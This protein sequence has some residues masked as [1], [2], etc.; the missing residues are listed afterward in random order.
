ML[1]THM[2]MRLPS[3]LSSTFVLRCRKHEGRKGHGQQ[4]EQTLALASLTYTQNNSARHTHTCTHTQAC[5]HRRIYEVFKTLLGC[6]RHEYGLH[7]TILVGPPPGVFQRSKPK[8]ISKNKKLRA[9]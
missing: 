5:R 3:H 1:A 9:A 2:L 4:Y 8:A 6:M 7:N